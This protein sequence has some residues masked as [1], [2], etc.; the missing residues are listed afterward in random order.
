M[1]LVHLKNGG[2]A[3]NDL[4]ATFLSEL[5]DGHDDQLNQEHLHYHCEKAAF[6]SSLNPECLLSMLSKM[7][8]SSS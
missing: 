7:N 6:E 1:T 3:V 2:G 5:V 8:N 4:A